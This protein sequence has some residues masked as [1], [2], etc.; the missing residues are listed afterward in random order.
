MIENQSMR[1]SNPQ[2]PP[3]KKTETNK[4]KIRFYWF[5]CLN[6]LCKK[7][8]NIPAVFSRAGCV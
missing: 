4:H 7:K 1:T 5:T 3:T 2:S 6:N 8:K